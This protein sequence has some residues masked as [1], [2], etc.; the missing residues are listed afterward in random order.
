M[1]FVH[2]IAGYD[3]CDTPKYQQADCYL[4]IE[5]VFAFSFIK[6][7]GK[8]AVSIAMNRDLPERRYV[9]FDTDVFDSLLKK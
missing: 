2:I 7:C 5:N 6:Y 3:A 9:T 1:K 4:N 8:R